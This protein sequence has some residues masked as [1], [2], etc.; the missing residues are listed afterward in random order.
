VGEAHERERERERE[1]EWTRARRE[2]VVCAPA[3]FLGRAG[4][5]AKNGYPVWVLHW[6]QFLSATQCSFR[7]NFE[8]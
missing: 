6:R 8:I 2:W 5:A 1:R 3:L 7:L 4:V